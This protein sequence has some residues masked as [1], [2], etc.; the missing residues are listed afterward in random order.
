MGGNLKFDFY[1]EV[2]ITKLATKIIYSIHYDIYCI[3]FIMVYIGFILDWNCSIQNC[4]PYPNG[5]SRK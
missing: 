3:G 2:F 5:P 1:E 4:Y